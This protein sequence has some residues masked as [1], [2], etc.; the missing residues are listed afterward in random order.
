MPL[1]K[2]G[3]GV[4]KNADGLVESLDSTPTN[5]LAK[6][7]V[8]TLLSEYIGDVE[9]LVNQHQAQGF[10]QTLREYHLK[11]VPDVTATANVSMVICPY[12]LNKITLRSCRADH[13]IPYKVYVRYLAYKSALNIAEEAVSVMKKENIEYLSS[14]DPQKRVLRGMPN[15]SPS[16]LLDE[17][18]IERLDFESIHTKAYNDYSNL[19]LCCHRC[20]SKKSD[21]INLDKALRSAEN[22][23][24][25][26]KYHRLVYKIKGIRKV[27]H[28]IYSFDTPVQVYLLE[29]T[30]LPG[31]G[32]IFMG[33]AGTFN[34]AK[35]SEFTPEYHL[36]PVT[37]RDYGTFE[38]DAGEFLNPFPNKGLNA[39]RI[40]NFSADEDE[41]DHN[42][43][44]NQAD[45]NL[46]KLKSEAF[47][48][49]VKTDNIPKKN[50]KSLSKEK[51]KKAVAVEL[52]KR[53]EVAF[54][55]VKRPDFKIQELLLWHDVF[56]YYQKKEGE[57][58][59]E[60]ENQFYFNLPDGFVI[61]SGE[62]GRQESVGQI[63]LSDQ[64]IYSGMHTFTGK[65]CIYC[66]GI[67][68]DMTFEIDHI[69][70]GMKARSYVQ[71]TKASIDRSNDPTNLIAV[72]KSCNSAK[73]RTNLSQDEVYY[74]HQQEKVR[75][76]CYHFLIEQVKKENSEG[77]YSLEEAMDFRSKI[78][79][80]M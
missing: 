28:E 56:I 4:K 30:D 72:C 41:D 15:K 45:L 7:I 33:L 44:M 61:E 2:N 18:K 24:A 39:K 79:S 69:N 64:M 48:E 1:G 10:N 27:L 23:A 11:K 66:F 43:R 34:R 12:C 70:P 54:K 5:P 16:S 9:D 19:L 80:K 71:N 76:S 42:L 40:N 3:K 67:Y 13:V 17:L 51:A 63:L 32:S 77:G 68:E 49:G 65:L 59:K 26:W 75:R 58:N 36:N 29:N 21:T 73:G 20:N 35:R 37:C 22:Y 14:F 60:G 53:F 25:Y 52:I 78:L 74:T 57:I 55:S 6:L 46:K 8:T 31:Q 50:K 47:P 62:P 38:R